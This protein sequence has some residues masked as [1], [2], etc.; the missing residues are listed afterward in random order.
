MQRFHPYIAVMKLIIALISLLVPSLAAADCVVLV[1]GLARSDDSM[2]VLEQALE[3]A[4]YEVVRISYPS[5]REPLEKLVRY[6]LPQAIESCVKT[7]VNFVTHSMGALL[8]RMYLAEN[9]PKQMGRVVMLAPPNKGSELAER[10][11][12]WQLFE[13]I[14]GPAGMALGTGPGSAVDGLGPVTFELGV[15]AGNRSLNPFFSALITGADDGKVSVYETK[16]SGMN[17]HIVLPVTHT[18]MMNSP[19][20]IAQVRLFLAGGAF[21]HELSYAD[22]VR[23]SLQ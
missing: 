4:G 17:D 21:D 22:S 8:L 18:F 6:G 11:R 9:Q 19:L 1:H 23:L 15:I 2:I 13:I 14:N 7:K 12:G 10:L 16:I 20:V 5:T 3:N